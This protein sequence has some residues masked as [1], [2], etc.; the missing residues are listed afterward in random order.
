[1]PLANR[2]R[3]KAE[4]ANIALS[5][6]KKEL[7]SI[8]NYAFSN[9]RSDQL[10]NAGLL[11]SSTPVDIHTNLLYGPSGYKGYEFSNVD[12][13]S[14]DSASN[15]LPKS[16][17]FVVIDQLDQNSKRVDVLVF[18]QEPGVPRFIKLSRLFVNL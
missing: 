18:W 11:E 13:G 15:L 1:M 8:Q 10:A 9:I 3:F 7:E 16:R 12:L 17:A 14:Y 4:K 5:L 2:G 6:A